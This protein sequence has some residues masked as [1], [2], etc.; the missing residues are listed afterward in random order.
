[1]HLVIHVLGQKATTNECSL[2]CV[3]QCCHY[4]PSF[5][6]FSPPMATQLQ[7]LHL[8]LQS[9]AFCVITVLV[10]LSFSPPMA[11]PLHYLHLALQSFAFCVITF[12]SPCFLS[13]SPPMATPLHYLHLALHSFAFCVI[14]VPGFGPLAHLW[15][16]H[17]S[18]YT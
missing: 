11:T 5:W 6:S 18:I 15:L 9:F 4:S 7:Y 8:A 16:C 14:T 3:T 13:F 12:Y 2:M 1:M 17:Y 10:F